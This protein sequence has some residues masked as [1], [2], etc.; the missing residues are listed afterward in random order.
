[1]LRAGGV[2]ICSTPNK[3]WHSPFTGRPFNPFHVREF[4][5]S[6]FATLLKQFFP[7]VDLN[8]QSPAGKPITLLNDLLSM[9]FIGMRPLMTAVSLR[10]PPVRS[11]VRTWF[12][13][14]LGRRTQDT[15]QSEEDWQ[16]DKRFTVMNRCPPGSRSR[17]FVAVCRKQ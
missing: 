2:F 1:V 15:R 5:E 9:A 16:L 12:E 3:R 7:S 10:P 6:E 13:R 17:Y 14:R 8:H 4:E 11:F